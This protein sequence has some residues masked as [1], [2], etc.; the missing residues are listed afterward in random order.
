[1]GL[2]MRVFE[3]LLMVVVMIMAGASYILFTLIWTELDE[4]SIKLDE[5][6]VDAD[7]IEIENE[8]EN[9]YAET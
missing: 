9:E 7:I 1:V 5:I 8:G 3:I 6:L 2:E 4:L